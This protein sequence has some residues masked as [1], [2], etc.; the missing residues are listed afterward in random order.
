MYYDQGKYALAKER[1]DKCGRNDVTQGLS[2][3]CLYLMSKYEEFTASLVE[4]I[5]VNQTNRR[6]AAL[7]AYAANQLLQEDIYPFCASPLDYVYKG[8]LAHSSLENSRFVR[9]FEDEMTD[10]QT[11]WEPASNTTKKGYR[12]IGNLFELRSENIQKMELYIRNHVETYFNKYINS[13][14]LFIKEWPKAFSLHGWFNR[15]VKGGNHISHI[16]PAGWL[17]GVVYLNMVDD[18]QNDEGAIKFSLHGYNYPILRDEIPANTVQPQSGEIVLFPSSLF[19]ETIPL[20]QDSVRCAVAF[21]II[22]IK[23]N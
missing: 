4:Y 21:D 19:H 2:L 5:K 6:V 13:Q 16:H 23:D 10:I 12:T 1:F 8:Q 9:A 22:P 3:E 20:I 11:V 14:N 15:L 17:S 18:P 7:S